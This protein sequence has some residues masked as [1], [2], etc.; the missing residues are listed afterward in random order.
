TMVQPLRLAVRG[1]VDIERARRA[2]RTYAASAGFA[3]IQIEEI[4]LAVSELATNL[5]RY[6]ENGELTLRTTGD[7]DRGGVEVASRDTGPGFADVGVA[8]REGESTGGGL[9]AGLA[10]VRRLMDTLVI[11][12]GPGGTTIVARKWLPR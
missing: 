2:A 3:G 12:T 11:E 6:A 7:T 1:Q 4:V 8:M 5:A 10:G 9:G